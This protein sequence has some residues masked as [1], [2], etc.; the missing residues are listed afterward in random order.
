ML[1][2]FKTMSTT[3]EKTKVLVMTALMAAII[4]VATYLIRIP[5]PTTGGYSHLGDCMIFLAIV[6]L[7]RRNGSLAAGLGGALSDFLAG[8]PIWILP[9]LVI[10]YVMGFIM[11]TIIKSYPE[12]HKL[13]LIGAIIGGL[14]QIIAYTLVKVILIGTEAAVLSIPNV[15]LQTAFGIVVFMI[16]SRAVGKSLLKFMKNEGV[17]K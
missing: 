3:S 11:G 15:T 6:I 1:E 14:F 13:Q 9:T 2:V 17:V 10:K 8:A 4:F 12:S 7:G 16:L 5:N